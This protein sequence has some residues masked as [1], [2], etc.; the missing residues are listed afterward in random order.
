MKKFL[1]KDVKSINDFIKYIDSK[2]F[3]NALKDK[4]QE[5]TIKNFVKMDKEETTRAA[6]NRLRWLWIT[7]IAKEMGLSKDECNQFLKERFL[8]PIFIRDSKEWANTIACIRELQ[9]FGQWGR[10]EQL[11]KFVTDERRLSLMDA[12]VSQGSEFL[13]EVQI[14]AHENLK[15]T[16]RTDN[17]YYDQAL[18]QQ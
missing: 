8:L 12:T 14:F 2:D 11:H 7:D 5:V 3:F 15:M 16:L 13:S 17:D 6:Q 1:L 18:C 10:A 4:P 9:G